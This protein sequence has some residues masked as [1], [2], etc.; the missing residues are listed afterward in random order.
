MK[1]VDFFLLKIL[2]G[3]C[4]ASGADISSAG[5]LNSFDEFN[6]YFRAG[7][8]LFLGRF[9]GKTARW[10]HFDI[11]A[12]SP[13]DRPYCPTGGEAQGIRALESLLLSRYG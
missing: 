12:W 9:V 3:V 10:V 11:F 2:A 8:D 7:L 13:T 6:L 1:S 4:G 5:G